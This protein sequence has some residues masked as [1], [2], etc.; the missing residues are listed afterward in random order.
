[1]RNV[2][3]RIL[4]GIQT[5]RSKLNTKMNK[6]TEPFQKTNFQERV[7]YI[8]DDMVWLSIM[9]PIFSNITPRI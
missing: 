9:T 5:M 8:I 6:A 7:E 1:M 4:D 3:D 2:N